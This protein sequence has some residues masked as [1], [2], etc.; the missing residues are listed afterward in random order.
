MAA[1]FC[2]FIP[3]N[4]QIHVI[5]AAGRDGVSRF[6]CWKT[7]RNRRA[8]VQ[9]A[10]RA[11]LPVSGFFYLPVARI[12]VY[13][14]GP[15]DCS[16]L[17]SHSRSPQARLLSKSRFSR[18]LFFALMHT[19]TFLRFWFTPFSSVSRPTFLFIRVFL[20]YCSIC[21]LCVPNLIRIVLPNRNQPNFK[22][23]CRLI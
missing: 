21:R 19:M 10:C 7:Y 1:A 17:R 11:Q 13:R 5:I 4:C 3:T 9:K 8:H 14:A 20:I 22:P 23:K 18:Y 2:R 15:S 6:D 12:Y 16:T